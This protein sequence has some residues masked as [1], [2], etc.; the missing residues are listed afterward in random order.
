MGDL[1]NGK[2]KIK[3]TMILV[4]LLYVNKQKRIENYL[5]KVMN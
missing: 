2:D 4:R 1:F 5:L 3:M